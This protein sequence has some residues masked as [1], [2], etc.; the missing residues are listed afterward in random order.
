[1][2]RYAYWICL[3]IL[4][5]V[6]LVLPTQGAEK[7]PFY[8]HDISTIIDEQGPIATVVGDGDAGVLG[9]FTSLWIVR[10][11]KWGK[12][13]STETLTFEV[14]EDTLELTQE[15]EWD[16]SQPNPTRLTGTFKIVGGTG[17]FTGAKGGGTALIVYIG[18]D[19]LGRSVFETFQE[20]TISYSLCD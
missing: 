1:M 5:A 18:Q 11:K 16:F 10:D 20:G 8:A 4:V 12:S 3:S 2:K 9:D 15:V 13:K 6:T 14:E 17:R 7:V 19:E